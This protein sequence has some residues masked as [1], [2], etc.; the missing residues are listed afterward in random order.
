MSTRRRT[1]CAGMGLLEVLLYCAIAVVVL[2]LC[3]VSFVQTTR[4]ATLTTDRILRQQALTGFAQ[5]FVRTVHGASR[6]L[7]SAGSAVTGEKS[8]VLETPDGPVAV[9]VVNGL[10]GIW[11]LQND[12][13]RW[14]V[15]RITTYPVAFR[16][17][18]F[19]LDAADIGDARR[20]TVHI[21]GPARQEPDDTSNDRVIVAGLRLNGGAS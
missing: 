3:A 4:L 15:Q 17:V 5:D 2:N 6:V 12:G 9:G 14:S 21:T 8:V 20:I 7:P 19:E 18:R 13:N 10:L 11:H 1:N 16:D